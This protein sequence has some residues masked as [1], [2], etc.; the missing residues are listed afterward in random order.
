VIFR[1]FVLDIVI[2]DIICYL[3][4]YNIMLNTITRNGEKD[5]RLRCGRD[6]K[7]MPNKRR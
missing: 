7:E 6:G 3:I 2:Y 1:P 4:L 5:W